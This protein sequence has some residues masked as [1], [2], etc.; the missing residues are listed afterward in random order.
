LRQV[1]ESASFFENMCIR[2]SKDWLF[3]TLSATNELRWCQVGSCCMRCDKM[4]FFVCLNSA[5]DHETFV[6]RDVGRMLVFPH[7]FVFVKNLMLTLWQVCTGCSWNVLSAHATVKVSLQVIVCA[8]THLFLWWLP[9]DWSKQKKTTGCVEWGEALDDIFVGFAVQG[10]A[11][12]NKDLVL[13]LVLVCLLARRHH[14]STAAD[15]LQQEN[16]HVDGVVSLT[17]QTWKNRWSSAV[18]VTLLTML[19]PL[20]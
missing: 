20:Y 7:W 18:F 19:L 5:S 3:S 16:T 1:P 13:T 15:L 12:R 10:A 17:S 4:S 9:R 14:S 6:S 8:V 2:F 11:T